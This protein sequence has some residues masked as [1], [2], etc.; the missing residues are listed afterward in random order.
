M[1]VTIVIQKE[2]NNSKNIILGMKFIYS[3]CFVFIY[4]LSLRAQSDFENMEGSVS[5]LSSQNIYVKYHSTKGIKIGDTLYTMRNKALTPTLIVKDLSSTSVLCKS[6]ISDAF[7]IN[8]KVTAKQKTEPNKTVE[9]GITKDDTLNAKTDSS[10]AVRIK[11]GNSK[12]NKQKVSG[13]FSIS[14]FSAFSNTTARK[15]NV[16]NYSLSLNISNTGNSEFSVESYILYRQEN[17]EWDNVR[18]NIFNGL[19]IYNLAVR[20]DI[21]KNSFISLGRKINPNISS[22]GAI[23]GLQTE[24]SFKNFYVGGFAGSRPSYSD[25]SFD[26]NLF[27]YGAYLGNT[28]Q[29]T[30]RS[31]QNSVSLVEQ[32]NR[33]NTDRQFLYFQHSSSLVQHV[34]LFYSLELD[35]YKVVN[36]QKQNVVNLTNTYLSLS[37]QAS[38][39]L[40]LSGTYD[41]RQNA[42]YY[43]TEKKYLSTLIAAETRQGFGSQINYQISKSFFAGARA[44]YRVQ[45]SDSRAS[46]NLYTFVT[47]ENMFTSQVST[48]LSATILETTYMNGNV[49]NA[50]FSRAY[51]SGKT[52]IS[53]GYSFVNYKIL[54][55]ELPL[56]QHIAEFN[57]STE[58]IK[59]TNVSLNLETDFEKPNTFYRLYLQVRKRF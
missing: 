2:N 26:I 10:E 11:K 58:L 9:R 40:T 32:T 49:Y 30:K 29:G 55:A 44:G 33:T 52:Y 46:K 8:D 5:F 59:K 51:N 15:S 43:E 6:I 28:Y 50:R 27:Q 48:T 12:I 47:Y 17:G 38:R 16:L 56:R 34:H 25:Y 45:K 42:I 39:K 57:I 35:L 4:I 1:R 22:I 18:K 14:D 37:Y 36:E 23:D 21:N 41:S 13:Q 31:M 53:L 24:K 19:K 3:F 54:R 20:Y 7:H